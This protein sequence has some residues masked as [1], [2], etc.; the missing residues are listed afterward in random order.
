MINGDI[1]GPTQKRHYFVVVK[2]RL[3]LNLSKGRYHVHSKWVPVPRLRCTAYDK[4]CVE[5]NIDITDKPT[6]ALLS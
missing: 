4:T 3:A 2:F 1:D 6:K 5:E